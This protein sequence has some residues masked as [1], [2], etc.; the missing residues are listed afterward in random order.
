MDKKKR[1]QC[2]NM[3]SSEKLLLADLVARYSNVIENILN[4]SSSYSSNGFR[5]GL[6][7]YEFFGLY[8]VNTAKIVNYPFTKITDGR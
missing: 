5:L 6:T 1:Q 8:A 2:C 7:V 3:T 4:C